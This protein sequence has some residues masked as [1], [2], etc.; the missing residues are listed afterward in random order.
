MLYTF[1]GFLALASIISASDEWSY[2][3]EAGT[4][5]SFWSEHYENCDGDNQSPIDIVTDD[6]EYTEAALEFS[7]SLAAT[8]SMT[9]NGHSVVLGADNEPFTV[10][11]D[12]NDVSTEWTLAQLHFH[13]GEDDTAGSEHTFDGSHYPLEMHLVHWDKA[14]SANFSADALMVVGVCFEIGEY[15]SDLQNLI[16]V[17]SEFKWNNTDIEAEITSEFNL[18]SLLPAD[19][20]TDFYYYPGSLTTPGCD[21]TVSWKVIKNTIEVDSDQLAEFR[22]LMHDVDGEA[23]YL[24]HNYRPTQPL[25][26]RV[27]SKSFGSVIDSLDAALDDLLD[28]DDTVVVVISAVMAVLIG[29]LLIAAA[30]YSVKDAREKKK[31]KEKEKQKEEDDKEKAKKKKAKA[32]KKAKMEEKMKKEE[33]EMQHV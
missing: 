15:N 25:N 1:A 22:T 4:G 33:I 8:E 24:V 14:V 27:V 13:W 12:S 18:E 2:D 31:Q 21:E 19:A 5:P 6:A 26:D 9:F 28:G 11:T 29:I 16:D 10:V 32:D 17:F 3:D 30:I 7:L 23:E 20:A